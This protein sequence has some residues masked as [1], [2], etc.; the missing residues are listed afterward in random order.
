MSLNVSF[1]SDSSCSGSKALLFTDLSNASRIGPSPH[2]AVKEVNLGWERFRDWRSSMSAFPSFTFFLISNF[3]N[4]R[5]AL[6]IRAIILIVGWN[7]L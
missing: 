4:L 5:A 1:A 3:L 6:R 2:Y 7:D